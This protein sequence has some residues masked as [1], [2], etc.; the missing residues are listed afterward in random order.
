MPS[1]WRT[2]PFAPLIDVLTT[3]PNIRVAQLGAELKKRYGAGVYTGKL[4]VYLR[5]AEAAGV[6]CI[7]ETERGDVSS[8]LVTL[9]EL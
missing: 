5:K 8:S 4:Q 3:R 7:G 6:V 9:R 1:L 2:G